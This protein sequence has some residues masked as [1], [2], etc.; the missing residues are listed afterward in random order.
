VTSAWAKYAAAARN[1]AAPSSARAGAPPQLARA[2]IANR[3][4]IALATISHPARW[5]SF[6]W[7]IRA[8]QFNELPPFAAGAFACPADDGSQIVGLLAYPN[9]KR[10]T[11]TFELTGCQA[12]R[13]ATSFAWPTAM[14]HTRDWAPTS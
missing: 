4:A 6:L 13:M 3:P 8:R 5:R 7:L 11:V 1:R 14:A 10:V 12:S 2:A 9:G